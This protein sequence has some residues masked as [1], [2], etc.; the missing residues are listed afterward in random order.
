VRDLRSVR[1]IRK[2][3][4]PVIR[5]ADNTDP[6]L[7]PY[8]KKYN[9]TTGDQVTEFE[10]SLDKDE[11]PEAMLAFYRMFGE[12]PPPKINDISGSVIACK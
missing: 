7:A 1:I 8:F 4:E 5:E 2:K 11:W 9:V 6:R 3:R 12:T 10:R